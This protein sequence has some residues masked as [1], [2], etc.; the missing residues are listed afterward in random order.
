MGSGT[1]VPRRL[2]EATMKETPMATKKT[3]AVETTI[4]DYTASYNE[5]HPEAAQLGFEPAECDC[6]AKDCPGFQMV[7]PNDPDHHYH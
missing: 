3:A 5:A 6:G 2:V 4:E 7:N 1:Q